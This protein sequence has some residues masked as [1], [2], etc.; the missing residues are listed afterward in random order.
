RRGTTYKFWNLEPP[1]SRSSGLVSVWYTGARPS[2]CIPPASE[3]T[4]HTLAKGR[5]AAAAERERATE[6]AGSRVKANKSGTT[7]WASPQSRDVRY[8]QPSVQPCAPP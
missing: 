8:P 1:W 5:A 4:G 7:V 2:P 3:R 6:A